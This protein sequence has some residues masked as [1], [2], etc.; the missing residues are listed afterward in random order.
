MECSA[1]GPTSVQTSLISVRYAE[2]PMSLVLGGC[3]L[4]HLEFIEPFRDSSTVEQAAVNR[5]VQGSNPCPGAKILCK[6][7]C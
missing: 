7:G 6:F 1:R 5:K 4:H 3:P 2:Q